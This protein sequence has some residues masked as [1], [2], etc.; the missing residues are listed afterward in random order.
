MRHE[1]N[2]PL[3]PLT[4]P[5][6]LELCHNLP[7]LSSDIFICS[8]PKSGTT[9]MQ[10]IVLSL[11]LTDARDRGR[12]IPDYRHVS[13]YAPFYEI[14][15]HWELCDGD[16]DGLYCLKQEIQDQHS[17]LGRRVFNTH[18]RWNM[19]PSLLQESSSDYSDDDAPKFIYVVRSP[20]DA[21]VSFYHHL[22]S[23]KE[24]QYVQG[25][26]AFFEDWCNGKI[27]FGSWKDHI[28]SFADGLVEQNVCRSSDGSFEKK[29]RKVMVVLYEDLVH[30]L[31]AEVD[32]ISRFLGLDISEKKKGHLLPTFS[33][34]SMKKDSNI[35]KFQPKSVTWIGDF[36]FLRKGCI[37]DSSSLITKEQELV[38]ARSISKDE[39][40]TRT[41]ND[42]RKKICDRYNLS[43]GTK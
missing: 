29:C 3:L 42:I 2:F 23:Q 40:W 12:D 11:L 17:R 27:P 21:C 8:Y 33:F 20:L 24:G 25:F 7:L 31:A 10:H 37:G 18:L 16:C 43:I 34:D 36:K 39:I 19:L 32:R 15:P 6:T 28:A 9:W 30:N 41:K 35:S 1:E 26:S 13:D 14:D 4:S 38:F 5:Q 22:S